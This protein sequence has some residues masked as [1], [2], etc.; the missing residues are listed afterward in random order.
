MQ[1]AV[2]KDKDKAELKLAFKDG[3]WRMAKGM[4]NAKGKGEYPTLQ[5]KESKEGQFTFK[6][7]YPSNLTFADVPFGPMAGADNPPDFDQQFTV[8]KADPKKI[9]V[10][11]LNANPKDPTA[12]YAGGVYT[13]ELRFK[14][15]PPLDPVI[16]NGGCC[17]NLRSSGDT[18][19]LVSESAELGIALGAVA[20]AVFV[21]ARWRRARS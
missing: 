1:K 10:D 20:L 8:R 4:E 2:A 21:A 3:K 7:D 11:V 13:Y 5:V 19:H 18:M 14:D 17:K 15:A 16:T 9:I 6:I 12:D